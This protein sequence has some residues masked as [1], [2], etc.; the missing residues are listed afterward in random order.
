MTD[1]KKNIYKFKAHVC[2]DTVIKCKWGGKG[3]WI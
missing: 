2:S 1:L 3:V